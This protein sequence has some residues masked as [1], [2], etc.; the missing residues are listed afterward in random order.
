LLHTLKIAASFPTLFKR[1]YPALNPSTQMIAAVSLLRFHEIDVLPVE[2]E[3]GVIRRGILGFSTLSRLM[4]LGPETWTSFL[5]KPCGEAAEELAGVRGDDPLE[6]LLDTFM[7][8]MFGFAV[9]QGEDEMS[10]L[11]GLT[12]VLSL[13]ERDI[14]GTELVAEDVATPM[15]SMP[16]DT[17]LRE[18]VRAMFEHRHRRI[19]VHDGDGGAA[20]VSDRDAISQMFNPVA[21]SRMARGSGGVLDLP[22]GEM[23]LRKPKDVASDTPLRTLAPALVSMRG[24]CFLIDGRVVTAWDVVMKPWARDALRIGKGIARKFGRG[25]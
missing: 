16:P 21:L 19:F 8:R 18:A 9:V 24:Q 17:T 12:D 3:T 7:R 4:A 2:S 23:E 5:E 25:A 6:E 11:L 13:Y 14:I 15:F 10:G 1:G 22:I 20:F